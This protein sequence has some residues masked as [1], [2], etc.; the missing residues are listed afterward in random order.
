MPVIETP[1]VMTM[2]KMTGFWPM[3]WNPYESS[4]TSSDYAYTIVMTMCLQGGQAATPFVGP[5]AHE[6]W[7]P[8]SH[9]AA[10]GAREEGHLSALV[11]V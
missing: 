10:G 8:G 7:G 6:R 11:S 5:R 4:G 2:M 1:S 3:S 9:A